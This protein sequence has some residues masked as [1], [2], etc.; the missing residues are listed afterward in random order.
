MLTP[1]GARRVDEVAWKTLG[2]SFPTFE[3][4]MTDEELNEWVFESEGMFSWNTN[5]QGYSLCTVRTSCEWKDKNTTSLFQLTHH[6]LVHV[7]HPVSHVGHKVVKHAE[8]VPHHVLHKHKRNRITKGLHLRQSHAALNHRW[9]SDTHCTAKL[10]TKIHACKHAMCLYLCLVVFL[11]RQTLSHFQPFM[12]QILCLTVGVLHF[13]PEKSWTPL[14]SVSHAAVLLEY[15][16]YVWTSLFHLHCQ[17]S[18]SS[19]VAPAHMLLFPHSGHSVSTG[20]ICH[21]WSFSNLMHLFHLTTA[22]CGT[23]MCS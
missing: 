21:S 3:Y 5:A 9:A 15:L 14:Y 11:Q 19:D 18:K 2:G 1:P 4:V 17:N 13:R 23:H 20:V 16:S 12:N 6:V 10:E 22:A 8:R 7:L